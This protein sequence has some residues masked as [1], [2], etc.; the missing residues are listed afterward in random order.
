MTAVRALP[1]VWRARREC[2]KWAASPPARRFA[3]SESL[4][5][6]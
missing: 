1:N 2:G 3:S 5:H 4:K 6:A